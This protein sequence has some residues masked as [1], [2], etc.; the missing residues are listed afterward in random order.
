VFGRLVYSLG[1][2]SKGAS[3]RLL[4]AL[5]LDLS[6]LVLLIFTLY[7]AF[8]FGGGVDGFITFANSIVAE[9]GGLVGKAK[10]YEF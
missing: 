1:Y 8:K 4:G 5:I 9:A 10:S 6:L 7:S 2:R 3:G